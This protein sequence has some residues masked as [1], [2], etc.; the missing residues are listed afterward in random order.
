VRGRII[1]ALTVSTSL[2]LGTTINAVEPTKSTTGAKATRPT[3]TKTSV[4]NQMLADQVASRIKASG[5]A[6]GANVQIQVES[7]KVQLAGTALTTEQQNEIAKNAMGVDGVNEVVLKMNVLTKL[8]QSAPTQN[9]IIPVSMP[10]PMQEPGVLSLNPPAYAPSSAPALGGSMPQ[11]PIPMVA[12]GYAGY[13]QGGPK[14]PGYA[15]PT[16]APYNNVSRVAYP[17]SYPYNAFP[18]I[19]PFYPF[20]KV[21]LGWRTVQLSWEDGHWYMGRVSTPHD[22][23]RVRFWCLG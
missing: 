12:P 23:W 15:W 17:Q 11:D 4:G 22:Y 8:E 6:E 20:P 18:F 16:Y 21:P 19:G 9:R 14:M 13:E 3:S 1:L 2:W 7:G 5:C 10:A